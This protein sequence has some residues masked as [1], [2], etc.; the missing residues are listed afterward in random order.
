LT[1]ETKKKGKKAEGQLEEE[2][3]FLAEEEKLRKKVTEDVLTDCA[4]SNIESIYGT[5]LPGERKDTDLVKEQVITRAIESEVAVVLKRYRQQYES[6]ET[7]LPRLSTYKILAKSFRN[8]FFQ[9][10]ELE[11]NDE[12]SNI[13]PY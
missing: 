10:F 9:W 6:N 1:T 3:D 12:D 7:R 8:L 4:L 11:D 13:R 5:Y 2:A